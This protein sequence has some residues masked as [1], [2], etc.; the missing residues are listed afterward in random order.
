MRQ[1]CK[2]ISPGLAS[3]ALIFLCIQPAKPATMTAKT[4]EAWN[5]AI[6]QTRN[7][8]AEESC[9]AARF[10]LIDR[11]PDTIAK[12]QAGGILAFHAPHGG[13]LSVP[14]GLIHHWTGTAF[15]PNARAVDAVTALQDYDSYAEI[16]KPSVTSSK[17]LTRKGDEFTYRLKFVERGFG[18]KAGLLGDFR[19]KYY[20]L[21][22]T[23]GY[24]IT[25]STS[26]TEFADPGTPE[27]RALP[28]AAAH[29]YVE[30]VFTIVRYREAPEGLYVEVE[31]LTLSRDIPASVRWMARPLVQRFS[32][33]VMTGTLNRFRNQVA[34]TR[35]YESAS[36]KYAKTP[37]RR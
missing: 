7:D 13:V 34:A 32:R 28:S 15:I 31:T 36:G 11:Q 27:E 8:L 10:L 17:L 22:A 2:L 14:S 1:L 12:V 24:S 18:L 4:L 33:Q 23:T 21:T 16:Y 37:L 30:G 5:A 3:I 20:R 29:G 26:L 35:T 25:E 9:A 19:S 6:E